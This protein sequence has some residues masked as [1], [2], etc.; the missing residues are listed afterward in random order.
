M[1][2]PPSVC[3]SVLS[4][5]SNNICNILTK[6]GMCTGHMPGSILFHFGANLAINDVIVTKV[7]H[8]L[9]VIKLECQ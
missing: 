1:F 8:K 9:I 3:V 6:I 7:V 5:K 4:T 2:S